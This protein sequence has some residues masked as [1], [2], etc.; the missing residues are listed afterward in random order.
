MLYE[1]T[2][3]LQMWEMSCES[4]C[5][6][7]LDNERIS[8]VRTVRVQPSTTD[9][10]MLSVFVDLKKYTSRAVRLSNPRSIITFTNRTRGSD[11]YPLNYFRGDIAIQKEAYTTLDKKNTS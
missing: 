10:S 11:A 4:G 6:V 7:L 2:T 1:P 9:G 3:T 5:T 8:D